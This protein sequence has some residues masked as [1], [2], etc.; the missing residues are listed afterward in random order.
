MFDRPF[1]RDGLFLAGLIVG[2]LFLAVT[3]RALGDVDR[4]VAVF[5]MLTAVPLGVLLVGVVGGTVR[6]YRRARS[7]RA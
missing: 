2:G 7:T 1:L 4:P 3:V 6:E 5:N